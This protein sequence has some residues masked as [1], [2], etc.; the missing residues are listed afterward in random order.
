MMFECVKCNRAL[1]MD[2]VALHK[3][4]IDRG[5]TRFMCLSCMAKYFNVKEELLVEKILIN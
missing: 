3:R 1:H 4:M 5:A 2:E